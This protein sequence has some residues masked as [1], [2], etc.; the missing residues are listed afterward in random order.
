VDDQ[1]FEL[2]SEAF[3]DP[4]AF[5]AALMAEAPRREDPICDDTVFRTDAEVVDAAV[6]FYLGSDAFN[7]MPGRANGPVAHSP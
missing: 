6:A 4:A 7:G 5:L 1:K 3:E 2:P